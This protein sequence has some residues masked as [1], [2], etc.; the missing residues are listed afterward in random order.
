MSRSDGF[1]PQEVGF[2]N[3]MDSYGI[4]NR[5]HLFEDNKHSVFFMKFPNSMDTEKMHELLRAKMP[6]LEKVREILI[7]IGQGYDLVVPVA[8]KL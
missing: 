1:Y 4:E 5:V 7:D 8:K 6:S 3:M 2:K